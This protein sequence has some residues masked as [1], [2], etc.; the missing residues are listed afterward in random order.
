MNRG[1]RSE[2][3]N[4]KIRVLE[5]RLKQ[6]Y[7]HPILSGKKRDQ[8]QDL[9]VEIETFWREKHD[10]NYWKVENLE[11]KEDEIIKIH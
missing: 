9:E 4:L 7:S 11:D 1:Y 5:R 10:W 6:G 3:Q 2:F 8:K